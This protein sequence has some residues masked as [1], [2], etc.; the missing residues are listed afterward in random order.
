MAKWRM[1]KIVREGNGFGQIFVQPQ[2]PRDR[3]ADGG[4]LNRVSQ[5]RAQVIAGPVEKHLRLVFQT[6]KRARMN[7]PRPIALKLCAKGMLW[8]RMFSAKRFARFLGK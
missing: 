1:P 6:A 2:G 7:D 4:D 3:T 5:T 8:L